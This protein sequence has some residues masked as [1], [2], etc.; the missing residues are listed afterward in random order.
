[1]SKVALSW[2]DAVSGLKP[3]G[4][5]QDSLDISSAVALDPADD[6]ADGATKVLVQALAQNV[7]Y[8]LDGSTPTA[9]VGFQLK[10]G[11]PPV[12][13][14]LEDGVTVTIIEEAATADMQ[15]QWGN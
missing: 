7:R 14:L 15:Y 8:T 1:M 10:A 4:A 6:S 13:I 12:I 3:R 2:K 11:D 5:H 9:A